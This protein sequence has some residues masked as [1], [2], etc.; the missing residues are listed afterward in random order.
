MLTNEKLLT[1]LQ[2][3]PMV[4]NLYNREMD[5]RASLNNGL[6]KL[7]ENTQLEV[8]NKAFNTVLRESSVNVSYQECVAIFDIMD[9]NKNV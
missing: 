5:K 9:R 1:L 7:D 6:Y 3:A 2:K 8:A 4:K